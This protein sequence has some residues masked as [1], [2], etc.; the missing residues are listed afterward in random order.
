VDYPPRVEGTGRAAAAEFVGTF[1]LIF[2]GA[3][4]VIVYL[5]G[6]LDLVG[7]ALAHGLVLAIMVSQ[8]AHLSGGV[9]NPAVQIA[10]WVTGKM[11][12]PR[13]VAYLGAQLL[14]GAVGALVLKLFVPPQAFDAALGGAAALGDGISTGKGILLEAVGTFF[15]V[16]AVFAT[17]V[18]ARGPFGKTA[19][20]TIGL[21]LTFGILAIGP[22]TG[23][24]FN[25]ARWFGPALASGH[26]DDWFVWIVGPM[27]GAVLAGVAYRGLFLRSDVPATP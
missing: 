20:L 23:A 2:F 15:L 8:T 13:T 9:F 5:N 19:G 16:W 1:A 25:V 21:T 27:A 22:W 10:L 26:W 17:M 11:S 4:S 14:G 6:Q 3:G 7:V 12:S 24:A 18:D